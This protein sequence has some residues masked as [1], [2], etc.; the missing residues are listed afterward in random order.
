MKAKLIAALLT[1]ALVAPAAAAN[2]SKTYSYFSV[3]GS[4]LED[5]QRQLD[6][7]GPEVRTDG[8]RHAGAV[9]MTFVSRVSYQNSTNGCSIAAA[10]VTVRA[11]IILPHWHGARPTD[12]GVRLV[13]DTLSSDIKRHEETHV[14]I[15]KNHARTLEQSLLAIR[16]QPDCEAAV[17]KAIKVTE[18]VLA[19]HN[20]AQ[21]EFDR[22]EGVTWES[23]MTRLLQYRIKLMSQGKKAG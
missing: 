9:Q 21:A 17:A 19:K 20:A 10:S 12:P 2:V 15:A 6:A 1:A 3:G 4:T 7:R 22:I 11:K 16:R 13:W 23:R 8:H 14:M 18:K 5:I